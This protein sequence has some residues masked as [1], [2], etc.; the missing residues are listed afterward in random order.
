MSD[1][2]KLLQ[3][4]FWGCHES[5]SN[6]SNCL[7]TTWHLLLPAFERTMNIGNGPSP[8]LGL[9]IPLSFLPFFYFLTH[10]GGSF[11][12]GSPKWWFSFQNGTT[13]GTLKES[14]PPLCCGTGHIRCLKLEAATGWLLQLW[15]RRVSERP[16][17]PVEPKSGQSAQLQPRDLADPHAGCQNGECGSRTGEGSR[18]TTGF[19]A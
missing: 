5:N 15:R 18:M 6:P 2:G 8:F 12:R 17:L 13:R 10:L 19:R 4:P 16:L 1:A 9:M 11:F 7:R 14:T 3:T